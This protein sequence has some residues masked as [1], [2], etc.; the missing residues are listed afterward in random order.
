MSGGMGCLLVVLTGGL[1][2]LVMIPYT[3]W[4]MSCPTYRC[5]T[6]GAARGR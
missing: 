3:L 4:V 1:W 2:L 6:C 5:G